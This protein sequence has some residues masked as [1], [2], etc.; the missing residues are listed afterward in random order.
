M[1]RYLTKILAV[2]LT[3]SFA[4]FTISPA[5]AAGGGKTGVTKQYCKSHPTDPRC[6]GMK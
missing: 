1:Q 3:A 5:V 6:K 2:L 4:A